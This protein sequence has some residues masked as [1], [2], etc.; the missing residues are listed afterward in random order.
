MMQTLDRLGITVAGRPFPPHRL[1]SQNPKGYWEHPEAL[2]G[3]LTGLEGNLAVKVM[4]RK[5]IEK[6]TLNP[7]ND[8]LIICRRNTNNLANAQFNTNTGGSSVARNVRNI[9]IWY[10]KMNDALGVGGKFE[11]V[12]QLNMDVALLRSDPSTQVPIVAAFT[13]A[14]MTDHSE[15]I[16]NVDP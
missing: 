4:L 11:T 2:Y 13:S 6:V 5:L 1:R 15:A 8:R 14:R 16:G 10:G 7:A 9:G 3:D 12:P